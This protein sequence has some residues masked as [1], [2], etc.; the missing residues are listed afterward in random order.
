MHRLAHRGLQAGEGKIAVLP[1]LERTREIEALRIAP[2]RMLLHLRTAGIAQPQKLRHL[3][4]GLAQGIVDGGAEA[5]VAAHP[6]NH[7]EL[8]VAARNQQQKIGKRDRVPASAA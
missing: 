5:V 2:P 3:V 1:A 4:E 7:L 6:F 8:G